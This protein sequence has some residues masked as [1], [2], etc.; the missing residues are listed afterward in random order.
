MP[1]KRIFKNFK[2]VKDETVCGGL[3]AYTTASIS[4]YHIKKHT[5]WI[6][7]FYNLNQVKFNTN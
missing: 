6:R 1:F 4:Y 2:N 7:T 3:I 5:F